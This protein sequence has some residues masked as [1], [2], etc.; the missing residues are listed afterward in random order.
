MIIEDQYDP[1]VV[2]TMA[3]LRSKYAK[4]GGAK[5]VTAIGKVLEKKGLIDFE[6]T[7]PDENKPLT[8]KL[9]DYSQKYPVRK[10]HLNWVDGGDQIAGLHP[11]TY[12]PFFLN[13]SGS[14]ICRLCNGEESVEQLIIKSKELWPSEPEEVLVK[15]LLSF[16]LLME[17]MDL[18]EFK[19]DLF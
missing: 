2:A 17:E 18:I 11:D 4:D 5:F 6:V 9:E 15:D 10:H 7:I 1:P 3:P 14:I 16:L 13:I 12:L 19:G 8:V